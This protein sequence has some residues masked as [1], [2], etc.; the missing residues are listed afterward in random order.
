M[1]DPLNNNTGNA[2]SC[3]KRLDEIRLKLKSNKDN[4][5]FRLPYVYQIVA[6]NV[7]AETIPLVIETDDAE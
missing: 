6:Y 7:E 4:D 1:L 2:D 3:I 5:E